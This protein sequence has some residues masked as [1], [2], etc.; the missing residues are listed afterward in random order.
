MSGPAA[1]DTNASMPWVSASRPVAAAR[2]SGIV[3]SSRG[4]VIEMSGT[5]ARPIS[6]ALS[7]RVVSVMTANCETSAPVPAVVGHITVGGIA[8]VT[9][10]TPS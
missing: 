8:A 1:R 7:R 2:S 4:S 5:S 6:V 9:L 10:S 3:V